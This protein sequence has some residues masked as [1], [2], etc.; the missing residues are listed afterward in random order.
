[1]IKAKADF[2]PTLFENRDRLGGSLCKVVLQ[3]TLVTFTL[4]SVVSV[5]PRLAPRASV[6][7]RGN[8]GSCCY[9]S[10]SDNVI[11]SIL[12]TCYAP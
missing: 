10:L 3:T 11:N 4:L 1:M 9:L 8:F 12:A 2:P 6:K 5:F 7:D